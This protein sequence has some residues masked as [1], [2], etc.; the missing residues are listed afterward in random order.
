MYLFI[1]L[2]YVLTS[3][4]DVWLSNEKKSIHIRIYNTLMIWYTWTY[5]KMFTYSNTY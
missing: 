3:S 1:L 5:L 4:S 2:I